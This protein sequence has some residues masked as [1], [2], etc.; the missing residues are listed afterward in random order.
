MTRKPHAVSTVDMSVAKQ[1][2]RDVRRRYKT[3][4]ANI[5]IELQN[6]CIKAGK[7]TETGYVGLIGV[8]C[9]PNW[10]LHIGDMQS[11]R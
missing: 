10:V 2:W 6:V 11:L 3:N 8:I 5:R 4:T 7:V 9:S 1:L